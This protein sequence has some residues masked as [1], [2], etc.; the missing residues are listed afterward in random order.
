MAESM[1]G[2][3]KREQRNPWATLMYPY[4]EARCCSLPR[5]TARLPARGTR[6]APPS[7]RSLKARVP[8]AAVFFQLNFSD[9][10]LRIASCNDQHDVLGLLAVTKLFDCCDDGLERGGD[11]PVAPVSHYFNQAGFP[12][13]FS[14]TVL[15]SGESAGVKHI[16][17]W[18]PGSRPEFNAD[19]Q[20]GP[21][22]MFR[23]VRR[24]SR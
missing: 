1:S 13:L 11:W 16:A 4:G 21:T 12:A 20:F 18:S 7:A 14:C 24:L 5:G 3:G 9:Q 17:R 15:R 19:A 10:T 8:P 2:K 22:S 6:R 23:G